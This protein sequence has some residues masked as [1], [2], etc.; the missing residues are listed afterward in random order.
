MHIHVHMWSLPVSIYIQ[1]ENTYLV[2]NICLY[3]HISR[4][5]LQVCV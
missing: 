4:W 2:V 3:V 1:R 5:H